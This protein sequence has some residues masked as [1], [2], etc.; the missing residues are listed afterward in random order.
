MAADKRYQVFISSTFRDLITERQEAMRA[1]LE[2][3]HMP[4]GMELFAATDESAWQLIEDVIR[5]SDYYVLIIGGRY[6]SLDET[7]IGFTEK[8]YDFAVS[9]KKHVIALLHGKPEGLPRDQT[10]TDGAAWGRLQ[11][12]RKKVESK[13]TRVAWASPLELKAQIIVGLT[14]AINRH[15]AVGWIRADQ[16]PTQAN[17]SDNLALRERIAEL[18]K[19]LAKTDVKTD[20]DFGSL[21]Q[22]EDK[23]SFDMI[24]EEYQSGNGRVTRSSRPLQ[25]TWNA[26]FGKISPNL[27]NGVSDESLKEAIREALH[28]MA[29]RSGMTSNASASISVPN[30]NVNSCLLQ[31]RALNL[32]QV[33]TPGTL[34]DDTIWDLTPRGDQLM[35]ELRALKR[36]PQNAK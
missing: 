34:K 29:Y 5:Q 4:A 25:T 6:G 12:F 15:P 32:I 14:M 2:L 23:I 11:S 31:F 8:E 3:G 28:E 33:K 10:E 18:E 35:V 13:H 30:D 24:V 19:Q 1:V 36:D 21:S 7:G 27:L 16:V 26:V 22:G 17:V 20:V 9:L